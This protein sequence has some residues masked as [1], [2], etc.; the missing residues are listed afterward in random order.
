MADFYADFATHQFGS[1]VS[2]EAANIFQEVDGQLPIPSEWGQE[3]DGGPGSITPDDRPWS[4]VKNDYV[5]ADRFA[6]LASRVNGAGNRERFNYWMNQFL[7]TKTKAELR[8]VW[9]EYNRVMSALRSEPDPSIKKQK[10]N[11]AALPLRLRL[12]SLL[13]KMYDHFIATISTPG[14]LGVVANFSQKSTPLT[15]EATTQE[16]EQD[17]GYLLP[18]EAFP[19]KGY[20]GTLRVIV[21]TVR[22]SLTRGEDF[23]LKV[24]ILSQ[25]PLSDTFFYWR[26]FES[27]NEFSKLP[28]QHI[29]RGVYTVTLTSSEIKEGDFEYYI[30]AKSVAGDTA[31][32]PATAPSL[33]QTVIIDQIQIPQP[34]PFKSIPDQETVSSQIQCSLSLWTE[35]PGDGSTP[36]TPLGIFTNGHFTLFVRGTDNKIYQNNDLS[37]WIEIPGDGFTLD[38]PGGLVDEKGNL[39]LFVRGTDN[40]LYTTAK[41]GE[42]WSGWSK[43]PGNGFTLSAPRALQEGTKTHL[44]VRG[45]DNKIY[46]NT[47]I[48]GN[49]GGWREIP[50]N[51]L[52]RDAPGAVLD[53]SNTLHLFVRGTDD[54]IYVNRRT[55]SDVWSGW[56]EVSGKGSTLG[57]PTVAI[58]SSGFL[59]LYVQGTDKK[60]YH[61][62]S[63]GKTWTGWTVVLGEMF[64]PNGPEAIHAEEDVWIIVRGENSKLYINKFPDL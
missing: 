33:N 54:K 53:A 31:Y 38:G 21:P 55:I 16:L 52:T 43:I 45:T 62:K 46:M 39:Q 34:P 29:A 14:E 36:S 41:S 7:Y 24:L 51:G 13:G 59:H 11:T 37:Q 56:S 12:V 35:V 17:L 28:L 48:S 30:Q 57:G 6:A 22:T 1:E 4:A 49:W 42:N 23:T 47:R 64:T 32:F 9:G 58:D 40:A 15:I 18:P 10:A 60:V 20:Q 19:S 44:L 8:T 26:P 61:N 3:G 25:T 2:S 63:D 5:F 50:G 27:Q